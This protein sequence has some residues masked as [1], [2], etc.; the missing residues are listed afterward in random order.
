MIP[1][2]IKAIID[3][4]VDK[5]YPTGSFLYAVLTNDLFEAASRADQQNQ[6][7]LTLIC[8]YIYNYTPGMCWGGLEEVAAWFKFHK[9]HPKQAEVAAAADRERRQKYYEECPKTLFEGG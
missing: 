7:A 6:F 4:Y 2:N 5:G 8:Q 1:R 3:L 9:E